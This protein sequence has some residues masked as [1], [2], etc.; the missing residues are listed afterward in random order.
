MGKTCEMLLGEAD[1]VLTP[2]YKRDSAHYFVEDIVRELKPTNL[3]GETKQSY[4][5]H[6]HQLHK[7]RQIY[8][9]IFS[10]AWPIFF[11]Q[12]PLFLFWCGTWWDTFSIL[13][14]F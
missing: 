6:F 8:G 5:E 12:N 14:C 7:I 4:V 11:R 13:H 9:N 1:A 10:P 2:S 3:M